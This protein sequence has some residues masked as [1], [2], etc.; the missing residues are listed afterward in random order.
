MWTMTATT[1]TCHLQTLKIAGARDVMCLESPGMFFFL[2]ALFYSSD[3][4]LQLDHHHHTPPTWTKPCRHIETA[5][6]AASA[7]ASVAAVVAAA[8]A[9]MSAAP[10]VALVSAAVAASAATTIINVAPNNDKRGLRHVLG[11]WYVFFLLFYCTNVYDTV[12][13]QRKG[14]IG[15]LR[16]LPV[17]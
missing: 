16:L 9:S 2:I 14:P 1:N 13:R 4:D 3:Y 11:P 7:S 12:N 6:A 8:V 10:A 17:N 15:P 5:A